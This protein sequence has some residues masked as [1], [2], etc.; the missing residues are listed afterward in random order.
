[1]LAPVYIILTPKHCWKISEAA[2]GGAGLRGGT[3][4]FIASVERKKALVMG[5]LIT[6]LKRSKH[7]FSGKPEFD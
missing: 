2:M 7:L 5:G 3:S 4:Y 1:M 6:S